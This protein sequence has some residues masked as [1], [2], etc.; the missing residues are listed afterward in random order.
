[1]PNIRR[2]RITGSFRESQNANMQGVGINGGG[3]GK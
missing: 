2:I 3:C 1:M